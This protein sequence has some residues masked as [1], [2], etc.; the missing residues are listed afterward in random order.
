MDEP[1]Y[2]GE[3]H[4]WHDD[5]FKRLGKKLYQDI[6]GQNADIALVPRNHLIDYEGIDVKV[7]LKNGK[8]IYVSD[9][10]R[11]AFSLSGVYVCP[12]NDVTIRTKN[13]QGE[14]LETNN[15]AATEFLYAVENANKDAW[16]RWHLIDVQKLLEYYHEGKLEPIREV[17]NRDK[18]NYLGIF[19]LD[20]LRKLNLVKK[21]KKFI[22]P[23]DTTI[24]DFLS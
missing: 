16:C 15:M 6:Y 9:R 21:E 4:D 7:T 3:R 17:Q 14:P 24:D 22:L 18:G 1:P 12:L 20:D 5:A 10:Y 23:R 2:K 19:D 13:A 8:T 11:K